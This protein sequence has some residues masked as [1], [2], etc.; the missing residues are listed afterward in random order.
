[1]SKLCYTPNCSNTVGDCSSIGLCKACY[2]SIYYW[3][4]KSP[5]ALIQRAQ[6]LEVF[7]GRMDLLTPGNV[8][9]MN[10][11]KPVKPLAIMPSEF[12]KGKKR[13]AKKA[14]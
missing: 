5:R 14:V 4:K 10:R 7:C 1:M 3:H 6:Q 12:R 8:S 13:K 11:R 2:S 9:T